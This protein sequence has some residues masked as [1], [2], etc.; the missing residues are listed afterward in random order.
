MNQERAASEFD[1]REPV[2]V[3][4]RSERSGTTEVLAG[5]L[6]LVLLYTDV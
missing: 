3:R 1:G 2:V 4:V 6:R 5:V